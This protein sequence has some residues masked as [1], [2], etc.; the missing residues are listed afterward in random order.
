MSLR[1]NLI[2]AARYA[3]ELSDNAA[4]LEMLRPDACGSLSD[5]QVLDLTCIINRQMAIKISAMISEQADAL[6]EMRQ[7]ER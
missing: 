6:K 7:D 4:A 2:K 3:A 1:G 5:D